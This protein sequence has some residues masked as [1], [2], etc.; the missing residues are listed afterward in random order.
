MTVDRGFL[1]EKGY[2][3]VIIRVLFDL[4]IGYDCSTLDLARLRY[5]HENVIIFGGHCGL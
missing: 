4:Q 2:G 3:N 1:V 5:M